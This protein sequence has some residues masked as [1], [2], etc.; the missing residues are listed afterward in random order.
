MSAAMWYAESHKLES[1][2]TYPYY[3]YDDSCQWNSTEGLVNVTAI[4]N[5]T[6][7]NA[8]QLI[9]AAA[10]GPVSVAI[11]ADSDDFQYYEWGVFNGIGCGDNLDHG[12]TVVG[13]DLDNYYYIVRN[14]WGEGWG[15]MGYIKMYIEDG[16]GTCGIQMEPVWPET[17]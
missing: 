4:Y 2:D 13:Y 10:L 8:S 16:E 7:N 9:A 6:A 14:S 3:A 17:N 1:E 11:E 15:D 12:V 5:V